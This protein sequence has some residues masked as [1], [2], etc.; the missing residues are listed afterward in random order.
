[1]THN[2]AFYTVLSVRSI[3][4]NLFTGVVPAGLS[5]FTNMRFNAV[6]NEIDSVDPGLCDQRGWWDGMVGKVIDEGTS[7]CDAIL[8]PKGTYNAYGRAI[9]GS[10]G[11]CEDCTSGRYAGAVGCEDGVVDD[12]GN[13]V[14]TETLTMEQ[15]ILK[16]LFRESGGSQWK[17][18]QG[19]PDGPICDFE[20]VV[21]KEGGVNEGV[22]ELDLANFD[23]IGTIPTDI[24]K[25]P[26]LKKVDFSMN[27]IDLSFEG[28][29][30]AKKLEEI[31]MQ[32]AD[33][34]SLDG[35]SSAPA[36]KKVSCVAKFSYR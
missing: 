34:T 36:L 12:S 11:A 4:Y 25:L 8:C 9:T 29:Y 21:C 17:R 1:M 6:K 32:D 19:W 3:G 18:G 24:Y 7:G 14:D 13:I 33:L 26:D 27:A 30:Q 2:A 16:K 23:M 31:I 5:S 10:K 15:E 35:I 20:G 22:E 28:I